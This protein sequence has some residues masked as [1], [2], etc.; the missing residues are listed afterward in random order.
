MLSKIF[1]N[2]SKALKITAKVFWWIG[3]VTVIGALAF[4][5]L[6]FI[7]Y[8]IGETI[9]KQVETNAILKH[10]ASSLPPISY[11]NDLPKI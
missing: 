9:D 6:S 10:N 1:N 5:P 11:E 8:G 4:W 2:I 3:T 7:M